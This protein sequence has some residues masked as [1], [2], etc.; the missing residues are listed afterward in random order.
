MRGE[1]G[2]G[3]SSPFMVNPGKRGRVSIGIASQQVPC[4][5]TLANQR[6]LVPQVNVHEVVGNPL[7]QQQRAAS[8]SHPA[9]Q[10]VAGYASYILVM[11]HG[12]SLRRTS[13]RDGTWGHLPKAG[14]LQTCRYEKRAICWDNEYI[15]LLLKSKLK[16]RNLKLT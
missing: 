12:V 7:H 14:L 10:G 15:C 6:H 13:H 1:I 5:Q 2:N 3:P 16:T 9:L 4:R 8:V 11:A